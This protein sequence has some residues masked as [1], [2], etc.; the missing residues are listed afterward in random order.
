MYKMFSEDLLMILALMYLWKLVGYSWVTMNVLY[1]PIARF[2]CDNKDNITVKQ[3]SFP[4]F[5]ETKLI[6]LPL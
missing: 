2:Q 3:S 4:F 1:D 6:Q 5:M